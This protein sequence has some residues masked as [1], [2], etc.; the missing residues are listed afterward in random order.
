MAVGITAG[1]QHLHLTSLD[2]GR[3]P[4]PNLGLLSQQWHRWMIIYPEQFITCILTRINEFDDKLC[5]E[6]NYAKSQILN[7]DLENP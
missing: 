4:K 3:L 5:Y 6:I 2:V 7:V 1:Y